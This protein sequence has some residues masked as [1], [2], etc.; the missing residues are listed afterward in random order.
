M[1]IDMI[2]E[3]KWVVQNFGNIR[4][5]DVSWTFKPEADVEENKA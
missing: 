5:L 1:A 2:V 3:P 4:I